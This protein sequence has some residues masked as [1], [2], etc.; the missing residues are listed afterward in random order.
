MEAWLTHAKQQKAERSC[1]DPV[2]L[3]KL[4]VMS[5]SKRL[6]ANME[7]TPEGDENVVINRLL[8]HVTTRGRKQSVED[9]WLH[10]ATFTPCK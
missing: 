2:T 4:V 10:E 6:N 1:V 9:E 5:P 7:F 8:R 3:A